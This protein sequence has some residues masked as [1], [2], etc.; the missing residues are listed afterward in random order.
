[1]M[2]KIFNHSLFKN[3][4]SLG[5]IKLLDIIFPLITI[6]YLTRTLDI[7]S[8]GLLVISIAIYNIANII[9]DFGFGLSSPYYIS[10]N[11]QKKELINR[12]LSSVLTLK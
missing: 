11:K 2:K 7:N 8:F 1:M 10:L 9:T 6:P 3:A 5:F 12:Y 4:S